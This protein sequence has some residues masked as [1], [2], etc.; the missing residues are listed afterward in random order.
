MPCTH[1]FCRS[2]KTAIFRSRSPTV[3][4]RGLCSNCIVRN[5]ALTWA[6]PTAPTTASGATYCLNASGS[7]FDPRAILR[8]FWDVPDRTSHIWMRLLCNLEVVL[9]CNWRYRKAYLCTALGCNG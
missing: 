4:P 9:G 2:E 6:F 1:T 3:K 5:G 8:T 7:K